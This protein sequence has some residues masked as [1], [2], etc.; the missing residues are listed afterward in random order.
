[1]GSAPMHALIDRLP[2]VRGGYRADVPLAKYTWLRVGGA[3]EV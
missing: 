3:A 1:M 2:A